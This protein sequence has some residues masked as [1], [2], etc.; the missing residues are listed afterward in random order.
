MI[1]C[2]FNHNEL[3]DQKE[4]ERD[5]FK[6]PRSADG[7]CVTRDS[8]AIR[9]TSVVGTLHFFGPTSGPSPAGWETDNE[10]ETDN[11]IEH[12]NLCFSE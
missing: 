8:L 12:F 7:L 2:E 3:A 9:T 1:H 6:I 5:T 10:N 4:R 11:F